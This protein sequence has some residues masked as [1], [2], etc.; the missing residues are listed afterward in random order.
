MRQNHIG[1]KHIIKKQKIQHLKVV[2]DKLK[3]A[4]LE[5]S[6]SQAGKIERPSTV[7]EVTWNYMTPKEK[8]LFATP[9]KR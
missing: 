1:R 5:I 9:G 8:A 7:D 4:K 3:P 6:E 2:I